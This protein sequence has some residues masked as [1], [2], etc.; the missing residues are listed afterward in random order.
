MKAGVNIRIGFTL[1]AVSI[2]F[3]I[4]IA[5]GSCTAATL[6]VGP[7]Q[8][9]KTIQSAIN[10]STDGD[11][12]YVDG[13]EYQEAVIVDKKVALIGVPNSSG[14]RPLLTGWPQSVTPGLNPAMKITAAGVI[15]DGFDIR[16]DGNQSAG[17]KVEGSNQEVNCEI[18][19]VNVTSCN[20]G[21][22][23]SGVR[24]VSITQSVFIGNGEGISTEWAGN[25]T[26]FRNTFL[27]NSLGAHIDLT[28]HVELSENNFID[29]TYGGAR[30]GS[31]TGNIR[32][33]ST[34]PQQYV[35]GSR[36]FINNTGNF[37]SDYGGEDR[38]SD[39]I[40]DSPYIINTVGPSIA[41]EPEFIFTDNYPAMGR[42]S[43]DGETAAIRNPTV[44]PA[45]STDIPLSVRLHTLHVGD[46]Q[47][48]STIQ[49]AV[50]ISANGDTIYVHGG[51][52]HEAV[53]V[54][55]PLTIIGVPNSSG[56]RPII[57]GWPASSALEMN[58]GMDITGRGVT[59]DGFD[60][61]GDQ[62]STGILVS[63][64]DCLI[65]NI[66][67]SSCWT[68]VEFGADNT[69][70]T[71]SVFSDNVQGATAHEASNLILT[72]NNFIDNKM[73]AFLSFTSNA[74][75]FQN[76]FINNTAG[77]R[78]SITNNVRVNSTSPVPYS[79]S[80]S[81]F[82]NRT[83]NF[84]SNNTAMDDNHD[85]IA[86]TPY[87]SSVISD[88]GYSWNFTDDYPAVARWSFENDTA[89]IGE[90]AV[91]GPAPTAQTSTPSET[92]Q[93][94]GS[95]ALLAPIG[96]LVAACICGLAACRRRP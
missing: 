92:A 94:S 27:N 59:I 70:V 48:Y 18:G 12:I 78:T 83:G 60:I 57:A 38:N 6:Y 53:I 71:C 81:V 32:G 26:I 33:N 90:P 50:N 7:D 62:N 64:E 21:V 8:H 23:V 43:F 74:T 89:I 35:F 25:I 11:T 67:V 47:I 84:W 28:P 10:G 4:L 91:T 95:I 39:G 55:K 44:V 17:I 58:P 14:G 73:V 30:Q 76:N 56:G 66:T 69:T 77:V 54:D 52:Y 31:H 80:G 34:L 1:T 96:L 5:P 88:L 16:G 3:F 45:D 63:G 24:N 87:T 86:D 36:Q 49:R 20:T 46:G 65:R 40:G 82:T 37:W 15:V 93:E 19:D 22:L 72:R 13:D 41:G 51:E 75:F 61:R 9:Y 85:G 2:L 68:G 42:W 29:N 79:F